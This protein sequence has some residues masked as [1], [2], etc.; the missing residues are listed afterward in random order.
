MPEKIK[1]LLTLEN[2]SVS[3][4]LVISFI[5]RIFRVNEIL[6]FYYDQGRDGLVIWDLIHSHKFFLIGPTTG[7]AGVFRGPFYYYL[8]TPF[9]YLGNGNPVWPSVFLAFLSVCALVLMY[10]LAREIGGKRMGIIALILGAFSFEIIYA[11]RWLSN[12]T[13]ML[14]LS[15]TLV[16]CLFKIQDGKKNFWILLSFVLGL[17]FFHFGSSGEL[18]YFPAI[19][20]FAVY[21]KMFPDVKTFLISVGVFLLTFSPLFIFNLKHGGI[22]GSNIAGLLS[23]SNNFTFPSWQF[24]INRLKDIG[25]R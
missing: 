3:I 11:S 22:L 12:P 23:S 19:L 8:I 4:I 6:G 17:S 16:W 14:F 2:I 24:A 20:I 21:F 15:M 9:Y 25:M 13:P 1:K 10:C 18:F 5:L 7:L